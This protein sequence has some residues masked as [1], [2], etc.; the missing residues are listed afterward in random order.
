[1]PLSMKVNNKVSIIINVHNGEKFIENSLRSA[2]DQSYKN[3]EVI[4]WNNASTDKTEDIVKNFNDKRVKYHY[5]DTFK[6]LYVARNKA[7]EISSGEFITFLDVD[8]E[9]T[10]DS[11]EKRVDLLNTTK[12][13]ICI[14]NLY[15][16]KNFRKKKPHYSKTNKPNLDFSSLLEKYNICFLSAMFRT[17]I[18]VK[19]KFNHNYNILG[20]YDLMLNLSN[21]YEIQYSDIYSG[22][23]N[24]HINNYTHKN[25]SSHVKETRKWFIT[26]CFILL[27][28]RKKLKAPIIKNYIILNQT[29]K[30]IKSNLI[31]TFK[32]FIC[33]KKNFLY[34]RILKKFILFK[35]LMND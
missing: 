18:F 24:I 15:I 26:N 1:M 31:Q 30:I 12:K 27:K 16:S 3:I 9:L 19:F 28:N 34:F 7:L 25:L 2:L 4:I 13:E 29:E 33:K 10:I 32:Y 6:K 21:K 5:S 35:L 14:S 17:K 11:I 20:D 8:D 23:Y 22:T